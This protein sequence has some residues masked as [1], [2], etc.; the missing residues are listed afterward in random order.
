MSVNKRRGGLLFVGVVAA[1]LVSVYLMAQGPQQTGSVYP[2]AGQDAAIPLPESVSR[3]A[4]SDDPR[5]LTGVWLRL[6]RQALS[7]GVVTGLELPAMTPEG[8]MH[9]YRESPLLT[10]TSPPLSHLNMPDLDPSLHHIE[11]HVPETAGGIDS[12]GYRNLTT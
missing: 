3:P 10:L 2:W 4:V 7:D 5:D 9:E 11:I 1:L 12:A 8:E 6:G